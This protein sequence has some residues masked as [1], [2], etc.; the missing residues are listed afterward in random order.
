MAGQVEAAPYRFSADRFAVTG[1]VSAAD[2]FDDGL[3]GPAWSV[4]NPTITES[5]GVVTL[6]SPGGIIDAFE[7]ETEMQSVP[8]SPFT[9]FD[10]LG[11]F[12][13]TST[14]VSGLPGVNQTYE[15]TVNHG[16]P[17]AGGG[18][19]D[20]FFDII[21]GNPDAAIAASL[22]VPAGLGVLFARESSDTFVGAQF[23]TIDPADV[24]GNVVLRL[25]FDDAA[26]QFSGAF[27]LDG[28]ASFQTFSTPL[29]PS[30]GESDYQWGLMAGA[31]VPEPET[32]AM[33][34]AG[35]GLV[36]FMARRKATRA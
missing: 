2:E 5:G 14:W 22:G 35:L 26:N 30:A 18:F 20:E 13:G 29:S 23:L 24:T 12:T 3:V 9:V 15:M 32:Y 19:E 27:S 10:G 28:G 36:G 31:T 33:L 21:V 7:E 11:N 34:L 8:G 6:N 1:Q 17:V 16:V 25:S 4:V